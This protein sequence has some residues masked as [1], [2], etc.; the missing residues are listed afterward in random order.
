MNEAAEILSSLRSY[1]LEPRERPLS[2]RPAEVAQ[3]EKQVGPLPAAFRSYLLDSRVLPVG[4]NKA[5]FDVYRIEQLYAPSSGP[6]GCTLMIDP[7]LLGRRLLAFGRERMGGRVSIGLVGSDA[8]RIFVVG[9]ASPGVREISPSFDSFVR[10]ISGERGAFRSPNDMRAAGLMAEVKPAD[11][12]TTPA[13]WG[14]ADLSQASVALRAFGPYPVVSKKES[15][16]R[17]AARNAVRKLEARIDVDLPSAY[18]E[19]LLEAPLLPLGFEASL[20]KKGGDSFDLSVMYAP[21]KGDYSVLDAIE[22][23]WAEG[24]LPE[25]ALPIAEDSGQNLF[26]LGVRGSQS[27]KVYFWR[28]GSQRINELAPSFGGFVERLRSSGRKTVRTM[29]KRAKEPHSGSKKKVTRK[30]SR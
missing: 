20:S 7:A 14:D 4:L 16:S 13:N 19:F 22:T 25:W 10:G 8:G 6:F 5:H 17:S 24:R 28:H 23:Y 26:C 11:I 18:R 30:R 1:S 3:L 9:G 15:T 21:T 27:G 2:A 12:D 29:K